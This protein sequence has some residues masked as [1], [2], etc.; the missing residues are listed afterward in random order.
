MGLVRKLVRGRTIR[1]LSSSLQILPSEDHF[2]YEDG[3]VSGNLIL[4]VQ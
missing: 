2:G 1:S 3:T 4:V